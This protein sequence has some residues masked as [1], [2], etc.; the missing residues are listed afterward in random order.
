[1]SVAMP[2]AQGTILGPIIFLALINS[3]LRELSNRWKYVDDMNLTQVR[4]LHQQCS[5]QTSLDNLSTWVREH[6][7]KMN[8]RKCKALHICFARTP[9]TPEPLLIDGQ[10]LETVVHI[11]V[12]GVTIQSDLKW[13]IQVDYMISASNRKLFLLRRL[14][15]FGVTT[16][17]LTTVYIVYVRSTMEYAAPVW[18]PALTCTQ[19]AR[20]ERQQKRACRIILGTEYT[21]YTSALSTLNLDSLAERRTH[22]CL[23]FAKKLLNSEFSDWLPPSR[24]QI[25]GRNTRSANKL[26]I[27]ICRTA[28]HKNS[29]IPYMTNLLNKHFN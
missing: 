6:K 11:K 7:M 29:A 26:D 5:L 22:L 1:M 25:S 27:P 16:Q 4:F 23:T 8:S 19:S 2:E 17:N 28:R 12:L 14:K 15:R 20:L 21:D 10:T 9:P 3:A 13:D 18:H 24:K